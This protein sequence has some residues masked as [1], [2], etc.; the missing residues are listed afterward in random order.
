MFVPRAYTS[1]AIGQKIGELLVEQQ[2]ATGSRSASDGP[3]GRVRSQKL[4][5]ILG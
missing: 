4:G 2:H 1:F 5:D 3:A